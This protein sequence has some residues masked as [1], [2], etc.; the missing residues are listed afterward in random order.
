MKRNNFVA[1][2][3]FAALNFACRELA[4]AFG[5][6]VYLVGSAIASRE[7]RDVDLRHTLP[8]ERMRE[9]FGTVD[10]AMGTALGQYLALVVSRH[11]RTLTELPVD[12]QFQSE[13]KFKAENDDAHPVRAMGWMFEG[14]VETGRDENREEPE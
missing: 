9:L 2:P 13:S 4:C 14:R 1:M 10:L 12:Y 6:R 3:H 7:H 11:L 5:G 8:D